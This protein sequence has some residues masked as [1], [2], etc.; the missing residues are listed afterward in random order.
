MSDSVVIS[1]SGAKSAEIMVI[2][3]IINLFDPGGVRSVG[4]LSFVMQAPFIS[5]MLRSALPGRSD[6]EHPQEV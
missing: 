1:N 5:T 3:S 2:Q 6:L 4:L